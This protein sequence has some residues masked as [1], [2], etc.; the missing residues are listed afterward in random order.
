MGHSQ[1]LVEIRALMIV[2]SLQMTDHDRELIAYQCNNCNENQSSL[3]MA[4]TKRA[5]C[6]GTISFH[7]H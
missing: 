4:G 2:K 5:Q 1:A 6:A 7:P 3:L